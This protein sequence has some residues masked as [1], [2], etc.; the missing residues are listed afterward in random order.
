MKLW[1]QRG[2]FTYDNPPMKAANEDVWLKLTERSTP[3]PFAI[4]VGATLPVSSYVKPVVSIAAASALPLPLI[5]QPQ[6]FYIDKQ[7]I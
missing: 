6:W 2:F 4:P 3:A 1:Y 5:G 7:G